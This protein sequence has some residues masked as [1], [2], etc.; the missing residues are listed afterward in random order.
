MTT[1]TFTVAVTG[2]RP[3][4]LKIDPVRL[5]HRLW[6][7][8]GA[9]R[10]GAGGRKI[11][12]TALAEGADRIFADAALARGYATHALLPF[13]IADYKTTFAV[14]DGA[15]E[16]YLPRMANVREL[17]GRL[18]SSEHAYAE[19]GAM[20]VAEADVLIAIWDGKPAAG[21]GGTPDVIEDALARGCPVI[22]IDAMQDRLPRLL[23]M[24]ADLPLFRARDR[25]ALL[26]R[27]HLITLARR[28]TSMA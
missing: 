25:A 19:L 17:P 16:S 3:N 1:A 13:S 10:A 12:L 18:E 7:S 4:R 6:F 11:A 22:W 23:P 5:R 28:V 20:L 27:R 9:L 21:R 8:L 26:T 24:K 15:L 2:H 14:D